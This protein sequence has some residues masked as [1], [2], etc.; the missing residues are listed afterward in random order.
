MVATE[1]R[2]SLVA[3]AGVA[4]VTASTRAEVKDQLERRYAN[5]NDSTALEVIRLCYIKTGTAGAT[6]D[7]G[8]RQ[9]SAAPVDVS[10]LRSY[11][12]RDAVTLRFVNRLQ[13][14]KRAS[15]VDRSRR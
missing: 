5:V 4:G 13:R 8:D 14:T 7:A 2:T 6:G 12:S 9:G 11:P 3:A 15:P 1:N 10:K